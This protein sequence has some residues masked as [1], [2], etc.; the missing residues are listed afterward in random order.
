[1]TPPRENMSDARIIMA[2]AFEYARM[3]LDGT[4]QEVLNRFTARVM[5]VLSKDEN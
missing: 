4:D 2:S 1:M 5:S 3:K